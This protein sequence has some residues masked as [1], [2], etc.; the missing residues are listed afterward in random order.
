MDLKVVGLAFHGENLEDLGFILK[1]V[2]LKYMTK[3]ETIC[4][5]QFME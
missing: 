1:I 4:L 2:K 5:K 3:M